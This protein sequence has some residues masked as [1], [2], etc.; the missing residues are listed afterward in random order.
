MPSTAQSRV[1][2]DPQGHSVI[3]EQR[4]VSGAALSSDNAETLVQ[5]E[6][7]SASIR[8]NSLT[9]PLRSL[10]PECKGMVLLSLIHI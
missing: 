6:Y 10:S 1:S 2:T 3:L 8:P 5:T 9:I 4:F 7:L